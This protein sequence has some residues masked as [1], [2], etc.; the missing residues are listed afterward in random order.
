MR[1]S[2]AGGLIALYALALHRYAVIEA[3]AAFGLL[4]IGLSVAFV[5]LC[6]GV[7]S[8]FS[9][10]LRVI[11]GLRHALAGTLIAAAV[12][13]LP[14]YVIV[15]G[16]ALPPVHDISTDLADPPAFT[17]AVFARPDWANTL[18]HP[19]PTS[20]LAE[21]QARAYPDIVPLDLEMQ[22]EE[23]FEVAQLVAGELEWTVAARLP[24]PSPEAEGQIEAV[25]RTMVM[26]FA[27]DVVIRVRPAGF[28]A[29]FDVRSVSRYGR[30][31]LGQ[32]AARIRQVLDLIQEI[33]ER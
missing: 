13:A 7:Y 10:W 17:A 32:N 33:S 22:V 5:G 30:S 19:G 9:T 28:G 3:P 23:A 27:D 4:A 2:A 20:D 12:L 21:A 26:G 1:F 8:I 25:A 11:R 14:A 31:D 16:M 15:P 18:D 6:I 24:P 29:R